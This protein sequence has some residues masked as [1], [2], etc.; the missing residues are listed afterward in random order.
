[1]A[2]PASSLF[3]GFLGS[4]EEL[5]AELANY[6]D[7][8]KK[9]PTE[10]GLHSA[11]QASLKKED[12]EQAL[13]L[14]VDNASALNS[15][16]EKN[17][18]PAYNL[19]LHLIRQS[20]KPDPYFLQI[21]TQLSS[22]PI[23]SSQHGPGLSL[24]V[25]ST[26]FNIIP[27]ESASRFSVFSSILAIVRSTSSFDA[28][29]PQ[30]D[31]LE[32][33]LQTWSVPDERKRSCYLEVS[34]IAQ[35]AGEHDISYKYLVTALK[36]FTSD[37]SSSSPEAR[38]LALQALKVALERPTHYDFQDL[39][40]LDGI[41]A[42]RKSDSIYSQ[43]LELFTSDSLDEFNDFKDE[44]EGWIEAEGLD[45]QALDRKMRLLTLASLAASS[46]QTRSLPYATIAKALQIPEE[47]VEVW[48][49]DVIRAGLVEGKL[50]QL[51]KTFLIHRS[52]YRVFGDNQWREIAAR[53]DMWKTSLTSVLRVI[54]QEKASF[55]ATK[56]QEQKEAEARLNGTQS[57]G[58]G[59]F[60]N[61]QQQR[62]QEAVE[63]E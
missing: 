43:L 62:P 13:K 60:R 32:T 52:T 27:E 18:I 2:V 9:S 28:I 5:A 33:W 16:P 17:I 7:T 56:E 61:R 8:L 15:A 57:Q 42:L 19:L 31:S 40:A 37:S 29:R 14:L 36:T 24:T 54:K 44:H 50:S 12:K 47:D 23:S 48:V 39:T 51:N 59:G 46:G 38:K 20:T 30:L 41:Q 35:E 26:V 53:L 58:G 25:L 3:N 49:I 22:S 45:K 6:I 21:C 11:V 1:M 10:D 63:V 4:F 34:A 55:I